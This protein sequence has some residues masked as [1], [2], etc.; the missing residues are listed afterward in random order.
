MSVQAL[1]DV[2][3]NRIINS[4]IWPARSPDLNSCYFFFWGCLMANVYNSN[5]RTEELKKIFVRKLQVFLNQNFCRRCEEYL[6][7][8]GQHIQRLMWSVNCNYFIPNV[9]GQQAYWFIGKIRM[10]FAAGGAPAAVKRRAVNP[11]TKAYIYREVPDGR[12]VWVKCK[13]VIH[14]ELCS[15]AIWKN[16]LGRSD[17]RTLLSAAGAKNPIPHLN[18]RFPVWKQS[19]ASPSVPFTFR[20][21]RLSVSLYSSVMYTRDRSPVYTECSVRNAH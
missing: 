16:V 20:V 19:A 18:K 3:G 15:N 10:R 1:P 14:V 17:G 11:P 2:F 8:E 9:I 5:P 21:F 6:R 7:V 4:G 13:Y 12:L